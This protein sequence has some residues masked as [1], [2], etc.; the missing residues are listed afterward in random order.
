[1]LLDLQI[2]KIED[3]VLVA[4][5]AVVLGLHLDELARVAVVV[6]QCVVPVVAT[7]VL[8]SEEPACLQIEPVDPVG[9]RKAEK[10]L[11]IGGPLSNLA[12]EPLAVVVLLEGLT[13]LPDESDLPAV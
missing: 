3:P 11:A 10:N 1:L 6:D 2:R 4:L 12:D 9:P 8:V 13:L 7:D 5:A